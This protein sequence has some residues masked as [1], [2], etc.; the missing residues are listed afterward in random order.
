MIKCF[1]ILGVFKGKVR[2][3]VL[4]PRYRPNH[5]IHN[6]NQ[7]PQTYPQSY[8]QHYTCMLY[9]LALACVRVHTMQHDTTT[10]QK[11]DNNIQQHNIQ[12]HKP[13]NTLFPVTLQH[14]GIKYQYNIKRCQNQKQSVT[15]T[16]CITRHKTI[17]ITIVYYQSI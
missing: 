12:S 2:A 15:R 10:Q 4:Y 8:P 7:H 17:D 13:Q 9:Y 3:K 1:L 14:Y 5:F 11:H 16:I 6:Q